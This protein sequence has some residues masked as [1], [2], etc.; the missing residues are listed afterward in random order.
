MKKQL[1]FD[2][3]HPQLQNPCRVDWDEMAGDER[4][5][6][7][8]QCDKQVYWFSHMSQ[9]EIQAVLNQTGPNLCALIEKRPD[10][11]IV[12]ADPPIASR[13][14]SFRT[15]KWTA[16]VF[17]LFLG[18]TAGAGT[19]QANSLSPATLQVNSTDRQKD[20][21][22]PQAGSQTGIKGWVKD[23]TGAS[24]V[25]AT[26]RVTSRQTGVV[27]EFTTDEEGCFV[28]LTDQ[29]GSF[30][31]RV[32]AV[33]FVTFEK[34]KVSVKAGKLSTPRPF[35]L[36]VGSTGGFCFLEKPKP[37]DNLSTIF[38]NSFS[39]FKRLFS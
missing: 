23:A 18:W 28:F 21:T 24:V 1:E 11:T 25:N 39:G 32:E 5:R 2:L 17:S 4:Q 38:S 35:V 16:G 30:T 6:H 10:G 3:N 22:K 36:R 26:V 31:I 9:K 8:A 13:F 12:T 34:T 19:I 20:E 7:C 29:P 37:S 14:F 27:R 33:G 15:S